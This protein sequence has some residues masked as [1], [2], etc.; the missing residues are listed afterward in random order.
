[1]FQPAVFFELGRVR[2]G[3]ALVPVI[4][5]DSVRLFFS[6]RSGNAVVKWG[7]GTET[8][9]TPEKN[10]DYTD[11]VNVRASIN[12]SYSPNYSGDIAVVFKQGLRDVYSFASWSAGTGSSKV[13]NIQNFGTFIKQFPNLYS[14]M[15]N[16]YAYQSAANK[17]TIKGNLAD[18]PNFVER[19][20][21]REFE[22]KDATNGNVWFDLSTFTAQSNLKYFNFN[23]GSYGYVADTNLKL[24]G[25][26]SKLPTGCSY[27]NFFK[28]LTGSAITYT[29]GKVWA[30]SFD[31]LSIP[32]PLSHTELDNLLIDMDNSITTKIGAGVITLGG[33]RSYASDAAVASLQAKGFTVNVL[34]QELIL[35]LDS[36]NSSS[37]SGSGT[38]IY[39]LSGYNN[40]GTLLN[41]V[42][43]NPDSGGS[44]VFDGVD[45]RVSIADNSNLRLSNGTFSIWA[46]RVDDTNVNSAVASKI[47]GSG[48]FNGWMIIL[49]STSVYIALKDASTNYSFTYPFGSASN[50][51][52]VTLVWITATTW[53]LYVNGIFRQ[54]V[55]TAPITISNQPLYLG[56]SLDNFWKTLK[57]RIGLV[58]LFNYPQSDNDV[59]TEFNNNKTRFGL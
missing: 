48:S 54:T 45:D 44:L 12:K 49:N 22:V 42:G 56:K 16:E 47:S 20:M 46:K 33:Y 37:Y 23:G 15:L 18:V 39:D 32:L 40:N 17:S 2:S 29:A 28:C 6:T 53:K 41:G 52:N 7:D 59:L 51:V 25:D 24:I 36:S 10:I 14:I 11:G 31:T 26:L 34:R 55:T 4:N 3:T 57:G 13:L 35:N 50:W 19:I 38:T 30:S 9:W 21:I 58:K 5:A 1:M 43:F 8:N 27:F